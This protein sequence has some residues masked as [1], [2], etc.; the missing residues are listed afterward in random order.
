[1]ANKQEGSKASEGF[2]PEERAAMKERAK[3][4]K[5]AAS[6]ADAEKAL[7]EKI[8]EMPES[9]RAMAERIHE[10]IKANAP[11]LSAKLWYGMPAYAKDGEIVCFFQSADKFKSRYATFGFND[12]AN[13]DEGNMWPTSY[14]LT[15]LTKADEAKI[16]QLV[17]KAVS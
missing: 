3:E 10:L 17:K 6:K 11:E 16:V 4:L 1:M 14:G 7:L 9:D 15:K 5:V 2:S 12:A 8:A 13:I